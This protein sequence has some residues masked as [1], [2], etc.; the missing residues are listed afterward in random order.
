MSNKTY[1]EI[2]G[3]GDFNVRYT[4]CIMVADE[5]RDVRHLINTFCSANGL[6]GTSGLPSNMLS[7][8]TDAFIKFLKKEGFRELKT[9]K[10]CFSD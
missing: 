6:P 9:N 1:I 10:V 8:T 7:D 3:W 2:E 4:K 5:V